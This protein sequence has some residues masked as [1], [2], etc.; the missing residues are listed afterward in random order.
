[1]NPLLTSVIKPTSGR[2]VSKAAPASVETIQTDF[3]FVYAAAEGWFIPSWGLKIRDLT[4]F[5][6][7]VSNPAATDRP[8]RAVRTTGHASQ[9]RVRHGQR[10]THRSSSSMHASIL[11]L[12]HVYNNVFGLLP[13]AA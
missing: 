7:Y 1:M 4:D 10:H 6:A 11:P 13:V 3:T 5:I 2:S 12:V 9:K 8:G